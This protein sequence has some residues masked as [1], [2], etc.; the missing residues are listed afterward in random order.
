VCTCWLGPTA[1]QLSTGEG[2][3]TWNR[4]YDSSHA[5][6]PCKWWKRLWTS[7]PLIASPTV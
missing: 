1:L 2:T 4:L 6:L 7:L 3:G 5:R